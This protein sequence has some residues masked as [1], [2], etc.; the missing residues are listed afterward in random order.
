MDYVTS[1]VPA[2]CRRVNIEYKG[3]EYVLYDIEGFR[4][5]V[6][7]PGHYVVPSEVQSSI[8]EIYLLDNVDEDA[9][10]LQQGMDRNGI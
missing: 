6:T 10:Y 1:N 9:A 4:V 8:E 3:D 2:K 5:V 7:W